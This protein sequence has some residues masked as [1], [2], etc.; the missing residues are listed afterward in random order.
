MTLLGKEDEV[1]EGGEFM[2]MSQT[3][4]APQEGVL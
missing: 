1:R 3:G 2:W 4:K